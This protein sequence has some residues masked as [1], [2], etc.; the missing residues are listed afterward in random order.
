MT[1]CKMR[2]AMRNEA[3]VLYAAVTYDKRNAA[4]ERFWTA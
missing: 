4:D 2:E 1:G 3:Y